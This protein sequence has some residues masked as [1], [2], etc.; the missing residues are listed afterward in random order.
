MR[1]TG[2]SNLLNP[3]SP[4]CLNESGFYTCLSKDSWNSPQC[5][6]VVESAE[7]AKTLYLHGRAFS[8]LGSVLEVVKETSNGNKKLETGLGKSD[9]LLSSIVRKRAGIELLTQV[10]LL[11]MKLYCLNSRSGHA[12][13]APLEHANR[14]RAPTT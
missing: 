7:L 3:E 12:F 11:P 9:A 5:K 6:D 1:I 14:I 4:R 13:F 8:N 2:H 10:T